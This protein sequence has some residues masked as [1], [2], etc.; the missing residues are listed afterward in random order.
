[1]NRPTDWTPLADTDPVP[2]NPAA[3]AQLGAQMRTTADRIAEDVLFLRS[4]CSSAVWESEAGDA[5][6][7][8]G[9]KVASELHRAH[10]RYAVTADVLGDSLSGSGYAAQLYQAQ[11]MAGRALSQAQESWPSMTSLLAQVVTLAPGKDPYSGG[12][13]LGGVPSAP[14][15]GTGGFPQLMVYSG[16][17]K[18]EVSTAKRQYNEWAQDLSSAVRLLGEAVQLQ[19]NAAASAAARI[20]AVISS[21]GLQDPT[22]WAALW[23]D[24]RSGLDDAGRWWAENW[25]RITSDIANVLSWIATAAGLLAMIFAFIC[26]PL[27]V[28]LEA[29][30]LGLNAVCLI[31]HTILAATGYS[32][33]LSVCTD[34]LAIV[35][36]GLGAGAIGGI[37]ATAEVAEGV[38][39]GTAAATEAEAESGDLALTDSSDVGETTSETDTS[40]N[41]AQSAL[42]HREYQNGSGFFGK[43]S[44]EDFQ[45]LNPK[46]VV[47]NFKSVWE[48]NLSEGQ[49]RQ[50]FTDSQTGEMAVGKTLRG[51]AANAFTLHNPEITEEIG[52]LDE[53]DT[54]AQLTRLARTQYRFDMAHYTTMWDVSKVLDLS[55]DGIDKLNLVTEFM[56]GH[57]PGY[58][59]LEDAMKTGGSGG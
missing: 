8:K 7:A 53:P 52:K 25:Q 40:T 59:N 26:P 44:K 27:A 24:V 3:V 48:D 4:V 23:D 19:N 54:I 37:K 32:S 51:A 20:D 16:S 42:G 43:L 2:G 29:L 13:A 45:G 58:S 15:L 18:P 22:G 14:S 6:R 35:S 34:V 11:Q 38:E 9:E 36:D 33:W 47:Q 12:I 21:D 5:F 46:S 17:D 10:A 41:D 28:A 31:L 56:G 39:E 55:S 1:V 50:M 30:A 57:L 49:W